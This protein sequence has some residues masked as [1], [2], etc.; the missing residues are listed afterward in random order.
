MSEYTDFL[1]PDRRL[2]ILRLL[3][4]I[5]GTA[6]ESVLHSGVEALGHV[7]LPRGQIREDIRFLID[8]GCITSEWYG[9]VQVAQI[10]RR[11]AEVANGSIEIK[12]IKRP[13]IGV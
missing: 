7:R 8:N 12:G 13:S 11:G 3:T 6:N 9:D 5:N 2:C 10:T 1:N 4:D